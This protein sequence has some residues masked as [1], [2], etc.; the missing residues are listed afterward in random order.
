[1]SQKQEYH[2]PYVPNPYKILEFR[3]E[4]SDS[5]TLKV[6]WQGKHDP[7][8]F[9]QISLPGIGEAPI[10]ICSYHKD[11]VEFN[12]RQVGTVTNELSKLKAGDDLLIRGPYGKGYP[13]DKL[14]GN[15]LI[16]I[17][18]GCGL[19]PLRGVIEYIEANRKDFGDMTMFMGFR[20]PDNILFA[21]DVAR[22]KR[23]NKTFVSVD[24]NPA[25][26]CFD[27][28][29]GFVTES[30]KADRFDNKNKIAFICGPPVMMRACID[31]LYSKGFHDDQIFISAER[32]M[33]CAF[34]I[35][36]HCMIRGKY[37]CM[38]GPVFR[39]DEI[40]GDERE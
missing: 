7:G 22:W 35:C 24:R 30:L 8:Q 12:I 10:S 3:R 34:G 37:T 15:D 33:N 40:K 11:Y 27:G 38:D 20:T 2:N 25:K 36:G 4:A 23:E 21:K 31:I 1:M 9:F 26:T 32:L 17:G 14:K 39:Y 29:V 6:D 28:K 5:F 18:G 13:M 19:A 16:V